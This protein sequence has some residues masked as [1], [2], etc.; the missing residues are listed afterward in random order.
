MRRK[1]RS[2][3]FG[4]MCGLLVILWSAVW[5]QKDIGHALLL[6]W[7]IPSVFIVMCGSFCAIVVAF[8]WETVKSVPHILKNAFLNKEIPKKELIKLF[9][10]MSIK[11]RREGLLVLEDEIESIQDESLKTGLQMVID[12][13]DEDKIRSIKELEI[14]KTVERHKKCIQLFR[15]WANLAPSF[16][17]MGTFLGLIQ[18]MANFSDMS[19]FASAFATVLVTSFYGV[20]LANLVFAPLANKLDIKNSEE[21][22]RLE[23]MI[24]GLLGI[25]SGVNARVLADSLKA[26]LSPTEKLEFEMKEL[27]QKEGDKVID[28]AA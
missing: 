28:D 10:D 3:A 20:I 21:T 18:M 7:D 2:T 19:K 14:E 8:Q 16:G 24:E 11:A 5:G 26:F 23:M 27:K 17:M 12:G 13:F 1:D 6:L 22:N 25:Q 9:V 15:M 4:L